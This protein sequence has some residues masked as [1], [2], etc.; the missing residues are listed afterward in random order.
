MEFSSAFPLLGK[1]NTELWTTSKSEA[2]VLAVSEYLGVD[3]PDVN[4]NEKIF[5]L[6]RELDKQN[7]FLSVELS[8]D[9]IFQSEQYKKSMF[10]REIVK[11]NRINLQNRL[12]RDR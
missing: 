7:G 10:I 8:S 4:L 2:D 9:M 6:S 3:L 12:K 5:L 11:N 1:F